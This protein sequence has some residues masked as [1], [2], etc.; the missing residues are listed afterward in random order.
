MLAQDAVLHDDVMIRQEEAG[1]AIIFENDR[2]AVVPA[3]F[4]QPRIAA[5]L[6]SASRN[7]ISI[8]QA[9]SLALVLVRALDM[10]RAHK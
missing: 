7:A 6:R 4:A 8:G 10:L 5:D 1:L 9:V 2:L 3:Q